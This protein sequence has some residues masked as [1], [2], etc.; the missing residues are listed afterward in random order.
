MAVPAFDS[1][2]LSLPRAADGIHLTPAGYDTWAGHIVHWL[3]T[4]RPVAPA[5]TWPGGPTR[6][7]MEAP[8]PG[9]APE[10]SGL[11]PLMIAGLLAA[12]LR[13]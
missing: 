2:A 7:V 6:P 12:L 8:S 11:P 3:A 5:P 4:S 10:A 1:E 13:S 9:P